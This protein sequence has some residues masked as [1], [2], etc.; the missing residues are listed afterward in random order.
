RIGERAGPRVGDGVARDQVNQREQRIRGGVK[1][2]AHEQKAPPRY[3]QRE[4]IEIAKPGPME[5]EGEDLVG[6]A[7][8]DQPW[9]GRRG[10]GRSSAVHLHTGGW[11]SAG[12]TL[13]VSLAI[14]GKLLLVGTLIEQLCFPQVEFPFDAASR[15]IRQ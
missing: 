4:V 14:R 5:A 15:N 9:R 7:A 11:S 10:V 6:S 2:D 12:A 3:P 13:H 1:N 8:R